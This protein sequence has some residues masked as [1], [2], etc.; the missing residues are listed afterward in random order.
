MKNNYHLYQPYLCSY[1][2]GMNNSVSGE[3]IKLQRVVLL[4][5]IIL[6]GLKFFAWYETRSNAILTDALE[7][8]INVFAGAFA[9][10]SLVVAARPQDEDHPYGHGKVEFLSAGLEGTLIA[11]AGFYMIGKAAYN[12]F[13]PIEIHSIDFGIYFTAFA[14]LVN[15]ITG[16]YLEKQGRKNNVVQ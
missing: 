3:N 9:L 15:Y 8:I 10:Y 14:G 5:S 11:I 16:A 12:F 6:M 1:F 13:H 2:A 4:I 7:S